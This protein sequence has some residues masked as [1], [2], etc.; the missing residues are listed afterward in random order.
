MA[1]TG[2]A[3]IVH[4]KEPLRCGI[5]G[6]GWMLGKYAEAIRLIDSAALVAVASR[7]GERA[8]AAAAKHGVPRAHPSYESLVNDPEVDI[9]IN[10]LHNGL[11]CEWS[12]RALEAG[13]HVLCEKPLACSSAE[14]ERMFAAAHANKRWLME[15]F[16][17]RFHPQMAEAK[18]RVAAGEIG[19]VLYIRSSRTAYGRDRSNP[20]YWRDAGG[21]ALMDIGCYCVNLA[22]FFA[23]AEPQ[24]VSAH[25]HFDDQADID[26]TLSG[27]LEFAG[28]VTAHLVCSMEAEPSYTSEIIGT[29]GKLLIPHPWFPPT[30]PTEFSVTRRDKT[31]TIR[32]EAPAAPQHV[33]APFALEI[34]HF[35]Q[36]ARENRAPQFPPG[37]DVERDARGNMRVIEALL[38]SARK[39]CAV[40]VAT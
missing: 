30:W 23:E 20:R 38:A 6:T 9:V 19:R 3:C 11:H 15:G 14:I 25:A 26:L 37:T 35:C 7:D 31:E 39:R 29:E 24:R 34:D 12:V 33:L 32:V 22:R 21:G 40:E 13:K 27:T 36:S 17:Y 1:A 16:M 5:L 2:Y 28:G 4:T 10:A 18:R 8:K